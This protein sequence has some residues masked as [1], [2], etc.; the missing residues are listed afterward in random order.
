MDRGVNDHDLERILSHYADSVELKS[1][2]VTRL[3]AIRRARFQAS[4][5]PYTFGAACAGSSSR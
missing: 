1:L 4:P 5:R 3:L 2:L